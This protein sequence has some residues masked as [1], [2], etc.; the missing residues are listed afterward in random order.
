MASLL[1]A[2]LE[3]ER[4]WTESFAASQDPLATLAEEALR[5][6]ET[7]ETK[8]ISHLWCLG[9]FLA[10]TQGSLA[11]ARSGLGYGTSALRA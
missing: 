2:E 11:E 6:F 10:V 9:H 7:G 4:R 5:E 3:S 8:I 1:L